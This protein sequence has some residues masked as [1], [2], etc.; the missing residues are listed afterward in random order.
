VSQKKSPNQQT[1]INLSPSTI[2]SVVLLTI[3]ITAAL[4]GFNNAGDSRVAPITV[5][6]TLIF[7]GVLFIVLFIHGI[8][9]PERWQRVIAI[10]SIMVAIFTIIMAFAFYQVLTSVEMPEF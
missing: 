1:L 6:G 10:I 2:L 5:S 9:R 7:A 4:V 8:R 3:A